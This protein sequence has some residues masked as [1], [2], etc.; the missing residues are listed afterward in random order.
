MRVLHVRMCS[1][2]MHA[3]CEVGI[4]FPGPAVT[5]DC[6]PP[7]G[8]WAMNPGP[9]QGQPVLLS[10]G[11]SLR[12]RVALY[13]AQV[14]TVIFLPE[15]DGSIKVFYLSICVYPYISGIWDRWKWLW[16]FFFLKATHQTGRFFTR[17]P[18]LHIYT[19]ISVGTV[20]GRTE[21]ISK[22]PMMLLGFSVIGF[23]DPLWV[24][25]V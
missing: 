13:L 18:H 17:A 23:F 7:S 25:K 10:A 20:Y 2:Y 24:S 19:S 3:I 6:E 5:D 16:K 1:V 4:G 8:F 14:Y 9:L 21:A 15:N 12:P 11:T 22:Y